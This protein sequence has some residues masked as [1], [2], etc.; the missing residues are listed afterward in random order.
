[1]KK[2]MLSIVLLISGAS[3]LGVVA[4]EYPM[5]RRYHLRGEPLTA[6]HVYNAL[7]RILE[8]SQDW[9]NQDLRQRIP[10]LSEVLEKVSHARDLARAGHLEAAQGII[11]T[12]IDDPNSAFEGMAAH[13]GYIKLR[14]ILERAQ[15]GGNPL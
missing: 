11:Q 10:G 6:E 15:N 3:L 14:N 4:P 1:M 12:A 7:D 9:Y 13:Y 5:N 2:L 8:T